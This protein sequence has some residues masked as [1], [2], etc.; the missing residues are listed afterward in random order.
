MQ[1]GV[2]L[3]S[4]GERSRRQWGKRRLDALQ[5]HRAVVVAGVV[6]SDPLDHVPRDPHRVDRRPPP[7]RAPRPTARGRARRGATA[8][9][10]WSPRAPAGRPRPTC[11]CAARAPWHPGSSRTKRRRSSAMA[12]YG[13]ELMNRR[14]LEV[15][16][17]L[18]AVMRGQSM[19]ARESSAPRRG[20]DIGP[21][22]EYDRL[23]LV[24]PGR[25]PSR[26]PARPPVGSV[27][28]PASA[29]SAGPSRS[30]SAG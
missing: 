26:G 11:R 9:G 22:P 27:A 17:R 7:G 21:V 29:R 28:C 10:A 25:G 23:D 12:T 3:R 8:P 4:A 6:R 19:V 15:L 2:L 14:R 13:R 30:S 20:A 1:G 18:L 16:G 5:L 24:R